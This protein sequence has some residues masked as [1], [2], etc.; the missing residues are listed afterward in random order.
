MKYYRVNE[1]PGFVGRQTYLRRLRQIDAEHTAAVIV[2]Y[3]RRELV[4]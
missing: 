3:G 2:V 1:N 4:S